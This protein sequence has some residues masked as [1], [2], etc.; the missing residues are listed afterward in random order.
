MATHS[1]ILNLGNPMVRGA[2]WATV[3][4]IATESDTMSRLN[5]NNLKGRS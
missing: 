5:D 2:L 1:S 3:P 4:G